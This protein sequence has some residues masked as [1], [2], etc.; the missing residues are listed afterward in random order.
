MVVDARSDRAGAITAETDPRITR[1]GKRL[2][3]TKLDELPQLWNV[4]CA[5]K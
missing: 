1:V 5:E 3:K 4:V 2:R